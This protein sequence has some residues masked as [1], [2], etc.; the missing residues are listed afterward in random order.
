M[1]FTGMI[2]SL[3]S[4]N[5]KEKVNPTIKRSEIEIQE[6]KFMLLYNEKIKDQS[7]TPATIRA[8]TDIIYLNSRLSL[9]VLSIMPPLLKLLNLRFPCS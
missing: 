7:I 8:T 6:K 5:Q 4:T 1:D 9:F 3:L 2:I